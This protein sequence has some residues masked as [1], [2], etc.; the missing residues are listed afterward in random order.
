[1]Y[2]IK[3]FEI[4]KIYHITLDTSEFEDNQYQLEYE[5]LNTNDLIYI[6]LIDRE[7]GI[8]SN[9]IIFYNQIEN[10]NLYY[11]NSNTNYYYYF[12]YDKN[13]KVFI[14]EWSK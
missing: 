1:M 3:S 9:L 8:E 14:K 10:N 2:K 5:E 4:N 7:Q 12:H 11:Y 6:H 13:G